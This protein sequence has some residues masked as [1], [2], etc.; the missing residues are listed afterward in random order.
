MSEIPQRRS[1][2]YHPFDGTTFGPASG[3]LINVDLDTVYCPDMLFYVG[4]QILPKSAVGDEYF[5]PDR[6]LLFRLAMDTKF[7][8]MVKYLAVPAIGL[9]AQGTMT[10]NM[11]PAIQKFNSLSELTVVGEDESGGND[12]YAPQQWDG[13]PRL[14]PGRPCP[15]GECTFW[16]HMFAG[17]VPVGVQTWQV[18]LVQSLRY[19]LMAED[20]PEGW[21]P[22][23][24]KFSE[25][26]RY[27]D[28]TTHES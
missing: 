7:A 3:T 22:P 10:E 21:W 18:K 12:S 26:R 5:F 2:F 25:C 1:K 20:G 14:I 8:E 23:Q 17:L 9:K 16:L 13:E 27:R 15:D 11:I 6:S 4:D 24:F 28:W 19:E